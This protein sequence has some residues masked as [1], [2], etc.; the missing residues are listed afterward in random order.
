MN[1]EDRTDHASIL[2]GQALML[3]RR[4]FAALSLAAPAAFAVARGS[5]SAQEDHFADL[6]IEN[7]SPVGQMDATP[8][9]SP[10]ASPAATEE[11]RGFLVG[12]P[13]APV[14]LQIYADYQCPH[15]RTFANQIE[16][17]LIEDYV[18]PGD[19]RIEFL[20]F[21][22]VGVPGLDALS[23]DSRE[24]VQA[25]EAAMC[26]AEQDA[27]L[28]YRSALF[29]GEMR[30]NSGAFSDENL[31]AMADELGLDTERF[32]ECLETGV[33]EDAVISFVYLA[34][35]RGVQGTP[36]LS[37]NG[38]EPFF[39]P[40]TGYDGIRVLLDAELGN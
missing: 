26:A 18:A 31:I 38:G 6:E 17:Q 7:A 34:I 32:T 36:S 14:T 21:T 29:S 35:E 16:P 2:E 27:Y 33:Y 4:R 13:D 11:L 15:C 8:A 10:Q 5:V 30:P 3:T 39:V 40:E 9:A 20:D 24:S 25:A 22:V 19:V 23:D 12:D 28:S 37:I 1:P